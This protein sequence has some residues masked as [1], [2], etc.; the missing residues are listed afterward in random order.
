MKSAFL[1]SVRLPNRQ[2][3]HN[4]TSSCATGHLLCN[5][6]RLL[7]HSKP[8]AGT[9]VLLCK[10]I[11]P[12]GRCKERHTSVLPPPLMKSTLGFLFIWQSLILL[13]GNCMSSCTTG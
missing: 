9:E 7:P 8:L 10:A 11:W 1:S 4:R 3:V 12:L 5:W 13:Q 6:I 2:P